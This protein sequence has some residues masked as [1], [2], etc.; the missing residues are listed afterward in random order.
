MKFEDLKFMS[1]GG[2]CVG[3]YALGPNRIK[4]PVDNV[5]LLNAW[6]FKLLLE[7]KYYNYFIT[8]PKQK[9]SEIRYNFK[10]IRI[11]HNNIEDPK[12]LI[13]LKKRTETLKHFL[14]DIK[15]N[16]NKYLIFAIPHTFYTNKKLNSELEKCIKY[17][18]E[19]NILDK[20]IF[21][22]STKANN[23]ILPSKVD[24]MW[25]DFCLSKTEYNNLY[26]KYAIN[27]IELSNINLFTA[28]GQEAAAKQF[29]NK[30][31]AFLK[32]KELQQKQK[33]TTYYLYF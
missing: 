5:L 3:L 12:Y 9:Y 7:D 29:K 28:A 16:K 31:T 17:L 23:V 32:E 27:Y 8:A 24:W 21:I 15:T 6:A 13:E 4:G 25:F 20:V 1:I 19:K 2:Y 11:Y 26:K 30:V 18:K 10:D 22:G 33:N 14:S